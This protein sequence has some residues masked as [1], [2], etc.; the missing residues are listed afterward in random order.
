MKRLTWILVAVGAAPEQVPHPV[1][2]RV[3]AHA[4]ASFLACQRSRW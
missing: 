1:A 2:P 3:G 4:T